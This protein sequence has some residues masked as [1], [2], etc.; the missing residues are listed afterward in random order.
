MSWFEDTLNLLSP[1]WVGSLIG[2]ASIVGALVVY[3]LTRQRTSLSYAYIG[4]HLLGSSSDTLPQQITVQF[5]GNPIP[6]L[7]RSII[8]LWNSGEKTILGEDNVQSDCLRF[9]VGSDGE[10]LSLAVLKASRDVNDFRLRKPSAHAPNEAIAEFNFFDAKDGVVVE[11]LHTSE[12]R[13]PSV[14]GTIRGIPKGLDA[15]GR[16]SRSRSFKSL[17]D[18]EIAI[19]AARWMMAGVSTWLP[20]ALG[21]LIVLIGFLLKID[22]LQVRVPSQPE[23]TS[24]TS[25]ILAGIAYTCMGAFMLYSNRRRYP[26]G[27]HIDALER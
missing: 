5:S 21:L 1:G 19:R 4:E 10:I 7:T 22:F 2:I 14:M 25:M 26:K 24:S 16:I 15:V 20:I 12:A 8:V 17:Q 23:N 11:I 9:Q 6:R 3:F 27:L 18:Q 13:R